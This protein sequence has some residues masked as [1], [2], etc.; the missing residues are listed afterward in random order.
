MTDSCSHTAFSAQLNRYGFFLL[1]FILSYVSASLFFFNMQH[2]EFFSKICHCSLYLIT[3]WHAE[4]GFNQIHNCFFILELRQTRL[5]VVSTTSSFHSRRAQT[6][7]WMWNLKIRNLIVRLSPRSAFL[8]GLRSPVKNVGANIL[9]KEEDE[10]DVTPKTSK[11]LKRS[12][13]GKQQ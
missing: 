13:T 6:E 7:A 4:S 8:S 12:I 9:K 2:N 11:G 3:S 1:S 5:S 10:G